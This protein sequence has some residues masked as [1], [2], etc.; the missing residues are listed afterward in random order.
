SLTPEQQHN[1]LRIGQ[2]AITNALKHSQAHAIDVE[3]DA[4]SQQVWLDI[5]DDGQGFAPDPVPA[6]SGFGM[7]SMQERARQL[8]GRLT[9]TS[10]PGQGTQIRITIPA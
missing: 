6:E 2:E 10:Q 1:L 7:T 5:R 4:D 3:I 9:I 8:N